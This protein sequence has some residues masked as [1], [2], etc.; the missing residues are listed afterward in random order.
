MKSCRVRGR[1]SREARWGDRGV[2]FWYY[3]LGAW[4]SEIRPR[5]VGVVLW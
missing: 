2:A 3:Q 4:L 1:L 5:G